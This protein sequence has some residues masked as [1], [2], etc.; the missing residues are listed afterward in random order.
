MVSLSYRIVKVSVIKSSSKGINFE[1]VLTRDSVT[2]AVDAVVYFRIFEPV[3]ATLNVVNANLAT[4]LLAQTTLRNL[5]GTLTLSEILSQRE[6]ISTQMQLQLDEA[7]G[8]WGINVERVEMHQVTPRWTSNAHLLLGKSKNLSVV[9][10]DSKLGLKIVWRV[11]KRVLY[12]LFCRDFRF[13][14]DCAKSPAPCGARGRIGSTVAAAGRKRRPRQ[15]VAYGLPLVQDKVTSL[16]PPGFCL[17][18]PLPFLLYCPV[19]FCCPLFLALPM[20]SLG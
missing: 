5:L 2:V 19:Y 8:L 17:L 9:V 14:E 15:V 13:R 6:H 11:K 12:D 4:K 16:S 3:F 20:W 7:T 18:S 1:R 10:S